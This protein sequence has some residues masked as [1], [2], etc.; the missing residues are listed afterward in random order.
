MKV[1]VNRDTCVAS[2]NCGAIAPDVFQNR[3][4]DGGF[5]RLLQTNPPA[6]QWE[7]V[8]QAAR[9]CPSGTINVEDVP[10]VRRSGPDQPSHS[11]TT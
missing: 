10:P 4:R 9:L 2:G 11:P 8:W 1:M 6:S 5:V 7:A 3:D